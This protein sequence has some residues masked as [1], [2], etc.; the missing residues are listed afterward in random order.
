MREVTSTNGICVGDLVERID[1]PE[2][3]PRRVAMIG[4]HE[5]VGYVGLDIFGKVTDP[6]PASY[7]KVV[8]HEDGS[9]A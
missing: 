7:Y 8:R 1:N 6:I 2:L 3:D 5:G 4:E 9:K